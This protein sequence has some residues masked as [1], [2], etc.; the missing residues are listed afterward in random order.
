MLMLIVGTQPRPAARCA[1][2]LRADV[3]LHHVRV[4]GG[5]PP[6]AALLPVAPSSLAN[7]VR[8]LMSVKACPRPLTP[9]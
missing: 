4:C 9:V 3:Y 1:S 5:G 6:L 2:P 7:Q 8:R